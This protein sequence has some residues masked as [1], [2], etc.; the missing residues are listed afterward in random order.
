MK[1]AL[2]TEMISYHTSKQA[3]IFFLDNSKQ[4]SIELITVRT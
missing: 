4:A 3:N 2:H 1:V